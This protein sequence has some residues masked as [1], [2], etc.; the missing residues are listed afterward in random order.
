MQVEVRSREN[1]SLKQLLRCL[2]LR[3]DGGKAGQGAGIPVMGPHPT[4]QLT[5]SPAGSPANAANH[6]THSQAKSCTGAPLNANCMRDAGAETC[7]AEGLQ[8]LAAA[9]CLA[10]LNTEGSYNEVERQ[11]AQDLP[12]AIATHIWL[13]L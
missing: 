6:Q 2:Q 8:G 5:Q 1:A 13:S 7:G 10:L 4:Q 3:P 11:L 12:P 9:D